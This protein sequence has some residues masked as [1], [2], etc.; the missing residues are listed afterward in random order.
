MG[1]MYDGYA[2]VY[3]ALGQGGWGAGLALMTRQPAAINGMID[4]ALTESGVPYAKVE[5]QAAASWTAWE[6]LQQA[7]EGAGSL[8]QQAM[9]DYLIENGAQT[10][11]HGD[12][13]FFPDQ[14]NYFEDLSKIKQVQDGEWY[15]VFPEE[16]AAPGA[17]PV[18]VLS[19]AFWQSRFAGDASVLGRTFRMNG[20]PYRIVGTEAADD[21]LLEHV[22]GTHRGL[23]GSTTVRHGE[24]DAVTF[25]APFVDALLA[26][27]P[28]AGEQDWCDLLATAAELTACGIH[29][30]YLRYVA[31]RLPVDVVVISGGGS[32]NPELMARLK[33]QGR[34]MV[35]ISHFLDD[36]LEA[37]RLT[38][39][40]VDRAR[41]GE[42][43][44]LIELRTYRHYSH[45]SDDDDSVYRD[46]DE[47]AEARKRDPL[48]KLNALLSGGMGSW[49]W[50][51]I[52]L[53]R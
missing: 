30:C 26:K 31:P 17:G 35:F 7:A 29:D 41:A 11:F 44:T 25:G 39:D 10:L 8:D 21:G 28:A 27:A 20:V 2:A 46:K 51:M 34:T 12:I 32:R 53:L 40:A 6:Y 3:D 14:Q 45:T 37:Y 4:A 50:N 33:A 15:T 24:G 9:C 52:P 19:H 18:A 5:T 1:A 49:E 43:P 16:F 22:P 47:I 42:G 48:V 13:E 36:V 23:G 38:K